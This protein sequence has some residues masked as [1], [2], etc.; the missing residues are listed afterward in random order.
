MLQ[1]GG[2]PV[3]DIAEILDNTNDMQDTL[4]AI[5][6]VTDALP[7]NGALTSI[8]SE[9]DKI[10]SAT[11][12]GLSGVHDSLAYRV[13]EIEHHL[14]HWNRWLGLANVPNGEIHRADRIGTTVTPFQV[15]AGDNTWGTWLQVLGSSDTPVDAGMAKYDFHLVQIVAVENPNATHFV[16]V[17]LGSSGAAALTAGAYTEFVFHPQSVQAQELPVP[18]TTSRRTSGTKA[19]IRT[20]VVGQDTSTIDF[21]I[22]LHE[23]RG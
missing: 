22:G 6:A 5:R 23:Y 8:S 1:I 3:S 20:M 19:W 13:E 9:T 4:N 18:I 7:D 2:S 11:T 10:D 15:D 12:D 21:F 14:H 16:Q 17:A